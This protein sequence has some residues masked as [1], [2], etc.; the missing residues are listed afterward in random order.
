V[1][2]VALDDQPCHELRYRTAARSDGAAVLPFL[3]AHMDRLPSD[4][5]CIVATSD[6]QGR[7]AGG[8]GRLLGEAVAEDLA[9]LQEMG[10]IPPIAVCL[11]G[12]DFFADPMAERMGVSGDVTD[13]FNAFARLAPTLGVLGNHDRVASLALD[14]GIGL[15]DGAMN[16]AAGLTIGGVAGIIGRAGKPM[17]KSLAQFLAA[18]EKAAQGA[19]LLITHQG[20]DLPARGERGS[21][22]IRAF[23]ERR[24]GGLYLFGHCHWH[25]PTARLGGWDVINIDARVIVLTHA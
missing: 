7:E 22:E 6:L 15:L 12:G 11:L 3:R 5:H 24:G 8:A 4:A 17:R 9:L 25:N 14:A 18:L 19:D 16:R 13:V 20:P 2:L 1:R 21:P 10:A 23:L